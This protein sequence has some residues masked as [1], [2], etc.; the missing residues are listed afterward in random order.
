MS[1]PGG[2]G[3]RRAA[4]EEDQALLASVQE[5]LRVSYLPGRANV[6]TALLTFLS[7]SNVDIIIGQAAISGIETSCSTSDHTGCRGGQLPH[8]GPLR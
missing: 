3:E 4:G 2:F 5:E 1:V 7:P 6:L 8:E